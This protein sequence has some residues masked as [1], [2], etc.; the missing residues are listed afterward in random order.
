MLRTS[1]QIVLQSSEDLSTL[2]DESVDLV[3]TSP[4]YPMI[5]MWDEVFTAQDSSGAVGRALSA[6]DGAEAF[7]LMHRLLDRV[8]RECYRLLKPGAF[9]CINIGDATRK[10]GGNFRLYPNHARIISS[11]TALGFQS[12]PAILWRKQTNGPTKFMGSGMLPAGAYVTLEHEYILV[13]RKGGKRSFSGDEKRRRRESAF[14]WEERNTWFSDIWD[15]KGVRQ[16]IE[17]GSEGAGKKGIR[18]RSAAF[19]FEIPYRLISMY[20]LIGETVLDPFLGTGT[21]TAAAVA[22]AR[23]SVGFEIEPGFTEQLPSVLE[24]ASF[25]MNDRIRQRFEDHLLFVSDFENRKGEKPAHVNEHYGFSVVTTQE[26]ELRIPYIETID[27]SET[28]TG[29]GGRTGAESTGPHLQTPSRTFTAEY[30]DTTDITCDS[31]P[32]IIY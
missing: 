1:H 28:A 29:G 19:P 20:S 13:F 10:V 21:T 30:R 3:V 24:R 27:I 9:A 16:R 23:N 5:E 7:E 18:E 11:C 8:W 15:L 2:A 17:S 22:A 14:F 4:P 26:R 12:L 31:S 6:G 32:R 25:E